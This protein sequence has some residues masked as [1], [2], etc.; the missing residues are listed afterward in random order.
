[1]AVIGWLNFPAAPAAGGTV[2]WARTGTN[3][4]VAT[5]T[6]ASAP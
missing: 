6:A 1:V 4:F 3:A 2:V 5:L